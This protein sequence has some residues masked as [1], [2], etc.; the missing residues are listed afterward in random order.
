[1]NEQQKRLK[2]KYTFK[3]RKASEGGRARSEDVPVW[4]HD[5]I[6][7]FNSCAHWC[8]EGYLVSRWSKITFFKPL[9]YMYCNQKQRTDAG[10]VTGSGGGVVSTTGIKDMDMEWG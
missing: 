7:M 4:E 1:L 5:I 8:G 3:E 2:K 6:E 10:K 9:E